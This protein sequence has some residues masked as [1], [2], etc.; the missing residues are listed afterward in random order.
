MVEIVVESNVYTT[1][2][3]LFIKNLLFLTVFNFPT[4]NKNL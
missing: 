4:V 3:P 2:L 1:F